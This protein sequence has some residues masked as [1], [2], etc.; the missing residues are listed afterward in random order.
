[1]RIS[2]LRELGVG[3]FCIGTAF[4]VMGD[5]LSVALVNFLGTALITYKAWSA[6]S[7]SSIRVV[8]SSY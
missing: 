1:M 3:S 7:S 5:L 6:L 4:A 2:D 8:V